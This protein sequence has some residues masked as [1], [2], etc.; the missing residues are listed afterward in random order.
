MNSQISSSGTNLLK[1]AVS[2]L[3]RWYIAASA[4]GTLWIQARRS[5]VDFVECCELL[6]RL[7]QTIG[8]GSI[9]TA[10][11]DL[12]LADIPTDRWPAFLRVVSMIA[13]RMNAGFRVLSSPEHATDASQQNT[14]PA[15][16]TSRYGPL[17]IVWERS[18]ASPASAGL[19]A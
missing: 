8:S 2:M 16:R 10:V 5:P 1:Q 13:T 3:D 19:P 15:E 14:V 6:K 11:L 12:G 17:C 18:A 9:H 7:G 4:Q